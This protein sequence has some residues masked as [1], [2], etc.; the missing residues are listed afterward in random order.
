MG[1]TRTIKGT[2]GSDQTP[3]DVLVY[4]RRNGL[5][6]YCVEGSV[7]VNC[8]DAEMLIDGVD[9]ETVEDYDFFTWIDGVSTE[10]EL[11]EAVES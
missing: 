9:V 5:S 11:T 4:D 8:T 7:N 10:D 2:Y 1:K 6:W 3:C